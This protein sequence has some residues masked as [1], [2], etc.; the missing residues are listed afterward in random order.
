MEEL[1]DILVKVTSYGDTIES[2]CWND[3]LVMVVTSAEAI[4]S[5]LSSACYADIVTCGDT[6][7]EK[8]ILPVGI[9]VIAFVQG[10]F[11]FTSSLA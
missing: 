7:F 1:T 6:C 5:A 4:A 2:L 10:I 11:I 3:C 8:H 9:C